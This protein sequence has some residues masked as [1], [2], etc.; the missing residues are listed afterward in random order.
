MCTQLPQD[1]NTFLLGGAGSLE[2]QTIEA[3]LLAGLLEG[4]ESLHPA[5]AENQVSNPG[6]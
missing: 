1:P 2:E 6:S 4:T 5:N 3:D